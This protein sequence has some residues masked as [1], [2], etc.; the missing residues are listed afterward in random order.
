MATY[1]PIDH[2]L[3]VPLVEIDS[4]AEIVG[5]ELKRRAPT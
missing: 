5:E 3:A 4:W 2:W 1:T